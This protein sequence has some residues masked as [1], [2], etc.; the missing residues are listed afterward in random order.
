MR[1]EFLILGPPSDPADAGSASNAAE[2]FGRIHDSGGPFASRGDDS[3]THSR[4]KLIWKLAGFDY[5]RDIDVE[6]NSWYYSTGQGMSATLRVA[7]ELGA[8]V[9]TDDATFY[10]YDGG[11]SLAMIFRNDP[12]LD[13]HYSVIPVSASKHPGIDEEAAWDYSN[14][15]TS[16]RGQELIAAFKVGGQWRFRRSDI[17]SWIEAQTHRPAAL[18]KDS[19]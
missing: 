9:L 11:L 10:A 8:Y 12:P 4:E 19:R 5:A 6:S 1:N 13:N 18:S 16:T 17:D 2:A 3:G 15:L 14:W 7:S